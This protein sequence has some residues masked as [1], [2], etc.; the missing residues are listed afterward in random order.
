MYL[1]P[2]SPYLKYSAVL[3]LLDTSSQDVEILCNCVCL[4]DWYVDVW[5]L[6]E[7]F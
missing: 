4:C 2:D 1:K 5:T 7:S 6:M 3:I